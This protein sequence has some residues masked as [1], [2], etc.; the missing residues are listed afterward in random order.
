MKN[1]VKPLLLILAVVTL[2]V[3]NVKAQTING[4]LQA[5]PASLE[6]ETTV[7]TPVTEVVNLLVL[8]QEE[9][10]RLTSP[11]LDVRIEGTDADQYSIDAN[12]VTIIDILESII[13]GKPV[14]IEVTYNPTETGTH[15]A[16]LVIGLPRI[17]GLNIVLVNVELTGTAN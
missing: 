16:T 1:F 2:S 3:T 12:T 11:L 4:I 8:N 10:S 13:T 5:D 15:F 17:L 14:D 9:L 7:G 6:F